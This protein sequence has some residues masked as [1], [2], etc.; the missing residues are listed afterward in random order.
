MKVKTIVI[1]GINLVDAGPLSIMRDFLSELSELN[2]SSIRILALVHKKELFNYPNIEYIEFPKSKNSW[3]YRIY[4]EYFHFKKLS[5]IIVP[6]YWIS[7]HDMTPNVKCENLYVYC[8]NAT[9]YYWPSLKDWRYGSRASLFSLLYIYLYRINIKKNKGVIVQQ[10][11]LRDRFA[12]RFGLKNIIVAY[13]RVNKIMIPKDKYKSKKTDTVKKIIFPSFPR[14]FKNFEIICEAYELL[15]AGYK[16]NLK[17]H[18]TLGN[19]MNSYADYII[20]RYDK[21]DG[22][23]FIGLLDRQKLFEFYD[24]M[25]A[26]VFPSKLESW[27]LPITE[28]KNF[29][30]P[31]FLARLPYAKETLGSYNKGYFFDPNSAEELASLFIKFVDEKLERVSREKV[32]VEDPFVEGWNQLIK[33]IVES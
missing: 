30:K 6:D 7:M 18:L 3:F 2:D 5:K 16:S 11:W 26:L 24:N 22:I 1:S 10:Q 12:S 33:Y 21:Y 23:K 31:I 19:Q 13:P 17:I 9:P 15:P 14:S 4:Y 27:G 8:H 29:D 20:K 28:F 32:K 25:D